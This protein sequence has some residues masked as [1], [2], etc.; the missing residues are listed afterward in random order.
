MYKLFNSQLKKQKL[1][2][3]KL[4]FIFLIPCNSFAQPVINNFLPRSGP[5]GTTVIISGNNFDPVPVNNNVFFGGV[6][7]TVSAATLTSL[8]VTVPTSATY[9]PIA[10]TVNQLTGYSAMP[11][12]TTF[13]CGNPLT[14]VSFSPGIK[15]P[16]TGASWHFARGDLDGDGKPDLVYG[17]WYSNIVSVYRN[18]SVPGNI[19][20]ATRIDLI[21]GT[22]PDDVVIC[23]FNADGKPDMVT[24]NTQGA[25]TDN[26]SVFKNT[27]TTGNI[28]FEPNFNLASGLLQG[29]KL[30]TGDIDGDGK[31]DLII[32]YG[33]YQKFSILRNT[34]INGMISFDPPLIVSITAPAKP[35]FITASDIDGDGK[36]DIA[37][38]T[39][40]NNLYV[41]RNT[42]IGS[43][44]SFAPEIELATGKNPLGIL[45]TD[46]DGDNKPDILTANSNDT[47][48]SVFRNTSTPGNISFAP[49]F[50]YSVAPGAP[51]DIAVDDADGDG[52]PDIITTSS[53]LLLVI[54]NN[55][56]IGTL[57]FAPKQIYGISNGPANVSAVDIDGD[58][59]TDIIGGLS[60]SAANGGG[61]A[62]LQN[63]LCIQIPFC[64]GGNNSMLSSL[65]GTFYQWQVNTGTGYTNLS[66]DSHYAN[67]NSN[68]LQLTNIPSSWYG[69][70]YRCVVDGNN[71]AELKILFIDQWTGA[72][73]T[74][75]EDPLNWSCNAVP[76]NFTDVYIQSGNVVL[77]STTTVGSLTTSLGVHITVVAGNVL[78]VLH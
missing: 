16:T 43:I 35:G 15:F 29:D 1:S 70:K 31:P 36:L 72:V 21:T 55:S 65:T 77:S 27:S 50:N 5:I 67:V 75:W 4:F 59:K 6:K 46:I 8:T 69:Y 22:H 28:S 52:K 23:D 57:S 12:I 7:A 47:T 60:R 53:G 51:R 71:S 10:V 19:S 40:Y 63:Q 68:L 64:P 17:D 24:V 33:E 25:L 44:I 14:P 45:S 66:N 73:S 61:I 41:L 13:G 20:M 58:G 38:N 74:A 34:S 26:I 62:I 2:F 56:S 32:S 78:T 39:S 3:Y 49:I 76:D 54:K 48:I 11:F 18:T 30:A 42:S 9:D 37:F